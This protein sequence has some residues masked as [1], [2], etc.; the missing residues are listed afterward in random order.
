MDPVNE[1]FSKGI[2]DCDAATYHNGTNGSDWTGH[3]NPF[4]QMN[5]FTPETKNRIRSDPNL[6]QFL[7]DPVFVEKLDAVIENPSKMQEYTKDEPRLMQVPVIYLYF[8]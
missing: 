8:Y 3:E 6:A 5:I 2:K 4:A 7:N 1:V